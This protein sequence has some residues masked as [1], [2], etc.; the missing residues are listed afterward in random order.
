MALHHKFGFAVCAIDKT[1]E[2]WRKAPTKEQHRVAA[3][4]LAG[5]L[6]KVYLQAEQ[7]DRPL[8][9][10]LLVDDNGDRDFLAAIER[11]FRSLKS[12]LHPRAA[13][14]LKPRF[15]ASHSDEVMQLA[16]MVCGASGASIDGDSMWYNL[17]ADRCVGLSRIP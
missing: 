3:T 15:R 16:D 10:Q 7:A 11:A 2:Y 4:A 8:R 1:T 5:D 6:H 17:I 12:L 9:D 13:M 14:V